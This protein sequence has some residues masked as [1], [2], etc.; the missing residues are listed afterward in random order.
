[1]KHYFSKPVDLIYVHIL[2][3]ALGPL[4]TFKYCN[5]SQLVFYFG[6]SLRFHVVT[7][8]IPLPTYFLL[9]DCFRSKEVG[10]GVISYHEMWVW[11]EFIHG[12]CHSHWMGTVAEELHRINL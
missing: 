11:S 12:I 5:V 7:L 4:S 10:N 2:L 6:E 9:N 1:M 8:L 3:N